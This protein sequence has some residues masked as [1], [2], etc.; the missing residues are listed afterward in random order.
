MIIM[1][2]HNNSYTATIMPIIYNNRYMYD[3]DKLAR[4]DRISQ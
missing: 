4:T 3:E 1:Q 2:L